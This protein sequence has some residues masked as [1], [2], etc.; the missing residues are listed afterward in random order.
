MPSKTSHAPIQTNA[1]G[2]SPPNPSTKTTPKPSL[3]TPP[4]NSVATYPAA[5]L[6]L[7]IF[8]TV[9]GISLFNL[10]NFSTAPPNASSS[11]ACLSSGPM[12]SI[13]LRPASCPSASTRARAAA[14]A[15]SSAAV[16]ASVAA[17]HA[18]AVAAGTR[19]FSDAMERSSASSSRARSSMR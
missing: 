17:A 19:R 6:A 3:P 10:P 14:A 7:S 16:P 13:A 1:C 12:P 9:A 5:T 2:I 18:P 15:A 11:S 8:A 4:H